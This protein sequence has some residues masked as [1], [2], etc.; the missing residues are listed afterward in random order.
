MDLDFFKKFYTKKSILEKRRFPL[1][2][3][4]RPPFYLLRLGPAGW[5][6]LHGHASTNLVPL[7][8]EPVLDDAVQ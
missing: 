3:G 8:D 1:K 2:N 4:V 6:P 7:D 5:S